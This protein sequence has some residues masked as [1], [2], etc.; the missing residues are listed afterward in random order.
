M[1]KSLRKWIG[2]ILS[3]LIFCS[4]FSACKETDGLNSSNLGGTPN[5]DIKLGELTIDNL[6][7]EEE[8]EGEGLLQGLN[9]NYNLYGYDVL[10]SSYINTKEVKSR[11]I[12]DEEKF[13]SSLYTEISADFKGSEIEDYYS[14]K[15]SNLYTQIN[16]SAEVGYK[17]A[18]FAANIKTEYGTSEQESSKQVFITWMEKHI[19]S[20]VQF[21]GTKADITAML[22]QQFLD[23]VEKVDKGAITAAQLFKDYG[24]HLIVEYYIGG[25]T[26]LNFTYNNKR[27]LTESEIRHKAETT[28]YSATAKTEG[29][30]NESAEEFQQSAKMK[31]QSFGGIHITGNTIESISMQMKAWTESLENNQTICGIGDFERSLYPI[32][33]ILDKKKYSSAIQKL[34]NEFTEQSKYKS[35]FLGELDYLDENNAYISDIIVV[36]ASKESKAKELV[37]N[38]YKY[39]CVNFNGDEILDANKGR[40]Y[41]IFIAYKPTKSKYGAITDIIVDLGKDKVH[42]GY[43]KINEDL[44]KEVGGEYVYLYYKKATLDEAVNPKTKFIREIRGQYREISTLPAG[45]SQPSITKDLNSGASGKYIYLMVRKY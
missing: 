42:E 40:K 4:A 2:L 32:W 37:P 35:L 29:S 34:G 38:G 36:G 12:L 26:R 11:P 33:E 14:E 10:N 7:E 44:N 21:K 31:F 15:M 23:D 45:W 19:L 3:V 6:N 8:D 30:I 20:G 25:R 24:T 22:S 16:G 39:V 5:P 27:N 1:I 17:N 43:T 28:Y 13:N 18:A 41:Y 9:K